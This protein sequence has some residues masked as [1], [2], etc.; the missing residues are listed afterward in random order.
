MKNFNNEYIQELEKIDQNYLEMSTED[1]LYKL[2]Q[3]L[4]KACNEKRT[5]WKLFIESEKLHY[6]GQYTAS[7]NH[8]LKAI[9]MDPHNYYFISSLAT[10]YYFMEEYNE[11]IACYTNAIKANSECYRAYID[12]A[13]VYRRIRE[14]SSAINDAKHVIQSATNSEI[15]ATAKHSLAR[16]Y[17]LSGE[18]EAAKEILLNLKND[19]AN[20]SEYY[21]ALAT[22]YEK[23]NDFPV[24][25]KYYKQARAL[26]KDQILTKLLDS[27]IK[28]YE[29]SESSEAIDPV[30]DIL[31]KLNIV[32]DEDSFLMQTLYEHSQQQTVLKENYKKEYLSSKRK[33][34]D[35][36]K[37]N[38]FLC[39]KGWSSS[40]PAFSLGKKIIEKNF[41]GGGLF[42]RWEG[43]GIIIDPGINFIENFH[44]SNL[45]AQDIN[46]VIVTH[47]HIDHK[48]DLNQIIDLDYQ[49]NLNIKY[50]LDEV[51]YSE[52]EKFF[53]DSMMKNSVYAISF[54][55]TNEV[56]TSEILR[57]KI[58]MISFK[59]MHNCSGSFGIKLKLQ[60]K[61]NITLSY[62]SDTSFYPELAG[63]LDESQIII[64]NF[65]ET[66]A[67]D[68][69]LQEYKPDHLGLNGCH[70]I[71]EGIKI[72][73]DIFFLSEFWGG[74][75]DIRIE[76]SKR[77]KSLQ[78]ENIVV[79][80][81]DI[82]MICT[83]PD[84]KLCCSSCKQFYSANDIRVLKPILSSQETEL[85]Y[86]CKNCAQMLTNGTT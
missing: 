8:T 75:G 76:I 38:Y 32:S 39:L 56:Y 53:E 23:S 72:K 20:Y 4:T 46:Y 73:P 13:S 71:L 85:R 61:E 33:R 58:T 22:A 14:Y 78:K 55:E 2:D 63:Y 16:T 34:D 51:T 1:I 59:T 66:N 7:L 45:Y 27:K 77:L 52:C 43:K 82:G 65:S 37:K 67:T 24:A 3:L 48:C 28:I 81:S 41:N 70:S 5:A 40:T 69:F 19:L 64:A 50:Y 26:C 62:T 42:I 68:L 86:L 30:Q 12:R 74:L 60:G 10:T 35:W 54:S 83:L 44:K 25:L 9:T 17:I 49:L 29:K 31:A 84:L 18:V 15:I 80:P 79:I 21:E 6:Q 57:N 11:A 47:N 36:M